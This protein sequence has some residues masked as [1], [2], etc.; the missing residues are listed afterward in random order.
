MAKRPLKE[1]MSRDFFMA[2]DI[3]A[4]SLSVR[5]LFLP[6]RPTTGACQ[7][8]RGEEPIVEVVHPGCAGLDISKKDAKLCVLVAG[9]GRGRAT[10]TV[11]TW[12]SM[13]S[14][15]LALRDHL[16]AEGVTCVVMGTTSDYWK[17]FFYL[18]VRASFV[19]PEPIRQL[20][21]LTRTRSAVTDS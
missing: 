14:R 6:V 18:L 17:P 3:G 21:D 2:T 4:L 20:R 15:I 8:C 19:P 1:H 16:A 13:T 10:E 9:S 12:S 11:T 7:C 5:L